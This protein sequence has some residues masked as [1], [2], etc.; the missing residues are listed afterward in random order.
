MADVAAV[1]GAVAVDVAGVED[2]DA[3]E[4]HEI[5]NDF[6]KNWRPIAT[7]GIRGLSDCDISIHKS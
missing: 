2:A 3:D 6:G 7:F 5:Y 1:I 4:G